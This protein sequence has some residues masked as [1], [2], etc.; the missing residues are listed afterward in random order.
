MGT[1]KQ[2]DQWTR[3][4]RAAHSAAIKRARQ[5]GRYAGQPANLR[6]YHARR[7]M[8]PTVEAAGQKLDALLAAERATPTDDST[9]GFQGAARIQVKREIH[10]LECLWRDHDVT[11]T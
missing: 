10:P 4:R 6:A 3:E 9:R 1:Q 11:T 2:R 8:W 7:G 5:Q